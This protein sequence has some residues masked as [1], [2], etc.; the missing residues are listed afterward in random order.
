MIAAAVSAPVVEE[1][2]F[3]GLVYRS[4]RN[5]LPVLPATL[6]A[7]AIFGAAHISVYHP[8]ELP[9]LAVFGVI[10]CQ[11]YERTGSLLPGIALHSFVDSTG[12]DVELTG[13]DLIVFAAFSILAAALLIRGTAARSRPVAASSVSPRS[14]L[15]A[16]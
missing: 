6:I 15:G 9:V 10:A 16:S 13:N 4:L 8:S 2:F 5:R 1:I 14:A 11:L 7:G 3:R 12:I